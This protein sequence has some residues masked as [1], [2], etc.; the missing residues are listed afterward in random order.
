MDNLLRDMFRG[1]D[2][3]IQQG[4][5]VFASARHSV[6]KISL[7]KKE[8]YVMDLTAAQ[9]GWQDS[10]VL[11]WPIFEAERLDTT[12]EV[13]EVGATSRILRADTRAAGKNME[14][15]QDAM[16]SAK[17]GFNHYL[18]EWQ[19]QHISFKTLVRCSEEEFR[20]KQDSLLVFMTKG[21]TE[22]RGAVNKRIE[23]M[24]VTFW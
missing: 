14:R 17:E 21:M 16:D 13:R 18:Q 10:A 3:E 22:I 4:N 24:G 11:P 19:R 15:H 23:T 2:V 1:M 7:S 8:V 5:P 9:Y 20:A 12:L 6:F